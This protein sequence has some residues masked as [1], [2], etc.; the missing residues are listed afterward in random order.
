MDF[1]LIL[2]AAS[3]IFIALKLVRFMKKDYS[4]KEKVKYIFFDHYLYLIISIATLQVAVP[5]L[6]KLW[7]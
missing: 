2:G 5:D 4:F 3:I 1:W 6:E 7:L